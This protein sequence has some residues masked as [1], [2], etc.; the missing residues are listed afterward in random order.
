MLLLLETSDIYVTF[1]CMYHTCMLQNELFPT[2]LNHFSIFIIEILIF[3]TSNIRHRNCL[4]RWEWGLPG[5]QA[6]CAVHTAAN[7]H[8]M[9]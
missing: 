2:D 7:L 4:A 3:K 5:Y 8:V 6:S 1:F 9:T